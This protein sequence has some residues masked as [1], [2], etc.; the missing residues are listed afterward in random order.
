MNQTMQTVKNP[1]KDDIANKYLN[2]WTIDRLGN[3]DQPIIRMAIYELLYT[4]T[5]DIVVINEA[6][7]LAK[8]YSDDKIITDISTVNNEFLIRH[9]INKYGKE[10]FI[11]CVKNSISAICIYFGFN[12]FINIFS[13]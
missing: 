7:E 3:T 8:L 13:L 9:A 12:I 10:H 2:K 11:S 5:P 4:E 1:S 6:L